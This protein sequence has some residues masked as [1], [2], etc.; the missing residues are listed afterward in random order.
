MDVAPTYEIKLQRASE[1]FNAFNEALDW[2]LKDNPYRITEQIDAHANR[3]EIVVVADRQ[4]PERLSLMLGDA[5]QNFRSGLDYIVGDLARRNSGGHLMPRVESDLQFPITTSRS[6]FKGAVR[7]ARLGLVAGR[8]AAH[9]QRMQPYRRGQDPLKHPLW[10]LHQLS[11]IDKHRR[12]PLLMSVVQSVQFDNIYVHSANSFEIGGGGPFE[13]KAVL[14]SYS[15]ADAK[16]DVNFGAVQV[17]VALGKGLPGQGH[18]P[19]RV[20]ADATTWIGTNI[21]TPLAAY[22]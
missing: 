1:H 12:I 10:L 3:T 14:A 22:L 5:V 15:P 2:W 21:F 18:D 4:P 19:A 20:L 17:G 7:Q 8:P 9:I 13:H 6:K 16:V 11:N